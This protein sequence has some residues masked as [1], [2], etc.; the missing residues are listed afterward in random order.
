MPLVNG[1]WTAA[2]Y[3]TVIA[4][5]MNALKDYLLEGTTGLP[6]LNTEP[7][8]VTKEGR[9]G[10]GDEPTLGTAEVLFINDDFSGKNYVRIVQQGGDFIVPSKGAGGAAILPVSFVLDCGATKP[11]AALNAGIDARSADNVLQGYVLR[12]VASFKGRMA[13]DALGLHEARAR[14]QP[15]NRRA[16]HFRNPV[17]LTAQLWVEEP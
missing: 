14:P 5:A 13:L 7:L 4:L 9:G 12:L 15:E 10:Q 2:D 1:T 16:G 11:M 17:L 3:P 8:F 6:G